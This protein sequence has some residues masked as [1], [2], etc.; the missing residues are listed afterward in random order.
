MKLFSKIS[1]IIILIF[2]GVSRADDSGDFSFRVG[3]GYDFVSQEYFISSSRYDTSLIPDP[4]AAASSILLEKDYLDDKKGLAYLKFN[5]GGEG[6]QLFEV[7]WEQTPDIFRAVGRGHFTLGRRENM[8]EGDFNI[9]FKERYRGAADEGEDLSVVEGWARYR[10]K[11]STSTESIIRVRGETVAF[12][13]TGELV[14]NYSKIGVETGFNIFAGNFN[15][16]YIQAGLEKRFVPDSGQLDFIQIRADLGY[17]GAFLGGQLSSELAL[18][19]KNY[20]QPDDRDDYTLV[21]FYNNLRLALGESYFLKPELNLEKFNFSVQDF[22][23]DDY[24]LGR[25][26]IILGRQFKDLSVS[27][28]P[29]VELLSVENNL[30]SN[31]DY[32]EYYAQAGIDFYHLNGVFL[33]FENQLGTRNYN[34]ETVYY[35]DFTF[36]RISLIGNLKIVSSLNFNIL[37]SA[38]WEWHDISSDDSRLYLLSSSLTYN[39]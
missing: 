23:S 33:L 12:D 15:L 18:E 9:E 17:S 24:L 7:G 22:I 38:E 39:F 16:F 8:L 4:D 34:N 3:M 2:V 37:L 29:K 28:G 10:R 11:L 20:N 31:D 6:R 36:D 21:T 1:G 30:E 26:G 27:L 19:N 5:A 14:Y 25:A 32:L 13:S 35:S